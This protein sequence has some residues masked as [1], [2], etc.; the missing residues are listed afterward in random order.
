MPV[1]D[2]NLKRFKKA[3][4]QLNAVIADCKKDCEGELHIPFAYLDG[5]NNLHL[6][7]GEFAP[8]EEGDQDSILV[9]ATLDA[10]GG[11]W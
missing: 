7:S 10:A 8:G 1:S 11:D 6:L 5:N 9:D 4:K 3:V 2:T